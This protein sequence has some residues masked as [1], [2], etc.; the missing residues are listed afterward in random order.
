MLPPQLF[1]ASKLRF[2][3]V[4]FSAAVSVST[5][6]VHTLKNERPCYRYQTGEPPVLRTGLM[7]KLFLRMCQNQTGLR[8]WPYISL[9]KV[10]VPVA[11]LLLLF[12]RPYKSYQCVVTTINGCRCIAMSYKRIKLRIVLRLSILIGT[13]N[14][15]IFCMSR[16]WLELYW[17]MMMR[18][19]TLEQS[20]HS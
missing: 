19:D 14:S 3:G 18:W 6:H 15:R 4:T 17:M 2:Q 1:S 16:S 5:T 11:R 9:T 10:T 8:V 12:K 7:S 13:H 20:T